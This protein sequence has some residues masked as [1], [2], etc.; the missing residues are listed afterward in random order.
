MARATRF[1]GASLVLVA[2]HFS[3]SNLVLSESQDPSSQATVYATVIDG[4]RKQV[5]GL[6]VA[7]LFVKEDGVEC[8]VTSAEPATAEMQ[9]AILVDDNGTGIFRFGLNALG[10]LLQGR[11]TISL[12]V[13]TN[14]VQRVFDYT[15]DS[16]TWFAGFGRTGL[17]PATPE[18]GQLLEGI[19]SA[20]RDITRREPRRPVIIALTVGGEEQSPLPSRRVLDEL[21]KSRASLH[22]LFVD[23][24]A[25]RPSKPAAKPSELLEGNFNLSRVLGDGPGESGGRHR[26]VLAMN[27]L[28]VEVQETARDLLAQYAITY[29][30]GASKN[31]QKLQVSVRRPNMAVIAPT[32]APRR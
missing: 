21:N 15:T 25:V 28:A 20:A 27:A 17:R 13:I 16:K 19:Y 18:G 31:P 11:A 3:T 4:Q 24:P 7:D 6:G 9:V 32:R 5:T 23:I 8:P 14:Q 22:V 12:S 26:E 2:L 1:A 29:S 30:R 10:E